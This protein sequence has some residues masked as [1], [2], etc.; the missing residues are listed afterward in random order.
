MVTISLSFPA[1]YYVY[2][3]NG[4]P[5]YRTIK[6]IKP[7]FEYT[8]V[9]EVYWER[10]VPEIVKIRDGELS[11]VLIHGI[12]PM[13]VNGSWTLYKEYF[14]NTWNS[15]LP[16]NCGLYIFIYPTLDVPLEETAK[17]L[18]D[19]IIKLNKK[20]NI[21]AH[22]MGGI[23]LRYVLQNEEFR[24]FVNKI[25]FAGTPHLGTPLANFVVL[26]K[27]VL[28]F[29][30]KWDIIKTVILMAN[31][32]WVFI[33]APNYKYLTFGFEKPEIPENINFMNFA[34]KI[35]ANTSSIV[36]NLINTDFFS[37]IALQILESTIKIIYPKDS[38]FTQNDG[39]VPLFSATYY[40]NEKVFEGFDHADLAI[41]ET[42]VKEAIKYFF[43]E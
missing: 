7:F 15:L 22:S 16:K 27:S 20:V 29:H 9:S 18:V 17:I 41:S 3:N 10:P 40:G 25:I 42:I 37:S 13:E 28:K 24:E 34:A 32:A 14:V 33:D 5:V 19:E 31:T 23:L 35:N 26:D 11:V 21:Y 43:G 30:P 2:Y 38:D 12:D 4:I 36:K 39:M 8:K 1:Q 6:E